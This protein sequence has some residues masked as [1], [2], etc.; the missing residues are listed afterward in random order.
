MVLL[1]RMVLPALPFVAV[2]MVVVLQVPQAVFV[3]VYTTNPK[4]NMSIIE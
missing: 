3:A 1:V 4:N 2:R